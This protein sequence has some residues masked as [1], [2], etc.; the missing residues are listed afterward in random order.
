MMGLELPD[1]I[2]I[3]SIIVSLLIAII[4]H[5]IMHGVVAY[6]YGDRTAKSMGRLSIN[7]LVH[8]DPVGS[9]IVPGLL[10]LSGAPFLFGWAKPVP[11]DTSVVIRNGGYN[12]AIAVALAGVGY[13]FFLALL[14]SLLLSFVD[15]STMG[16]AITSIFL[17]QLMIYNV[18][19]GVFNLWPIPPLDGSRALG[20]FGKKIGLFGIARFFAT[21]ETYGMIFIIVLLATPLS[22]V[23]FWPARWIMGFLL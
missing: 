21:I 19:L 5:E 12:G 8:I 14:A 10:Y 6:R 20:Y 22:Q 4:G 18:V 11:I 16:G 9:I 23:F 15:D 3:S 13:N 2:K 17:L 1:V 7:P